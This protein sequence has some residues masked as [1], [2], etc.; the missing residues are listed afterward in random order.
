MQNDH[1]LECGILLVDL[2]GRHVLNPLD[3]L[4]TLIKGR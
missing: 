1:I 2:Y 3:Y 4:A